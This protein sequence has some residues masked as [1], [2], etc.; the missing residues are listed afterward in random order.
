M[1]SSIAAIVAMGDTI[2]Q[3]DV[4]WPGMRE[5]Q[6]HRVC[7][8]LDPT[9]DPLGKGFHI[10]QSTI[11][12]GSGGILGK[13]LYTPQMVIAGELDLVGSDSR[14]ERAIDLV[15]RQ[16]RPA[17]IEIDNAGR[18]RLPELDDVD[19]A[20]GDEVQSALMCRRQ[21]QPRSPD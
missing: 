9:S 6:K 10:I 20:D 5:Y 21:E 19:D 11:A 15:A 4:E 13:G 16:R 14:L 7:T 18:V 2:C 17:V 12:I 3:P 8:L 1:T